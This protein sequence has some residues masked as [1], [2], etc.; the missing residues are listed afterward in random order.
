M[1]VRIITAYDVA[2]WESQLPG[3]DLYKFSKMSLC[4]ETILK[5][6]SPAEKFLEQQIGKLLQQTTKLEQSQ[7]CTCK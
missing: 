5:K 2:E 3:S 6:V 1:Y 7:Q 4:L